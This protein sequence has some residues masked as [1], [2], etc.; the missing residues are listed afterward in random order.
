MPAVYGIGGSL[1]YFVDRYAELG[2]C[3]GDEFEWQDEYD[4][5]PSGAGFFYID[6]LTQ[7][8]ARG[9]MST[10][11]D[12]YFQAF[13]FREIRFFDIKGKQT[14]LFSRA[15][16]SPDGKICIPVNESANENS[17]IETYLWEYKGEGI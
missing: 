6:H 10:W 12:F 13:D 15:L 11:D 4:P 8:V 9:N 17:Q 5:E 7:N 2:S 16:T 1:L 3:C 14:G